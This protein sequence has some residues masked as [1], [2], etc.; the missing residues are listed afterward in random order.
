MKFYGCVDVSLST[1]KSLKKYSRLNERLTKLLKQ[2]NLTIHELSKQ[3]GVSVGT[4]QKLLNNPECNPTISSIESICDVF[5]ISIS[6]LL[7]KADTTTNG[8][9]VKICGWD[10][11][12]DE[13]KEHR[14]YFY[15]HEPVNENSFA[16]KMH[17]SSMLPLFPENTILIF[18]N[19]VKPKNNS[20]VIIKR[21]NSDKPLFKKLIIDEPDRYFVSI[22]PILNDQVT[23]LEPSDKLIA[24]LVQSYINF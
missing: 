19:A 24:V 2:N 13:T 21:E 7:G 16:L 22:N 18:D 11:I 6:E 9:A 17:D 20:Y 4:V 3:S 8:S 10:N 23:K 1:V 5:N 12:L 14:E 15:T